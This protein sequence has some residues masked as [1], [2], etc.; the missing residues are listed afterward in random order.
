MS[1]AVIFP[2]QASVLSAFGTLVTPVRLDLVRS[3]LGLLDAID[4]DRTGTLFEQMAAEGR[5]F[6]GPPAVPTNFDAT[7]YVLGVSR[8]TVRE[9]LREL[10]QD[11][12]VLVHYFNAFAFEARKGEFA[13]P[14]F[15]GELARDANVKT[16]VTTHHGPW[17]DAD[18]TRERMIADLGAIFSG[19]I[20]CGEDLMSFSL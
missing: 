13:G 3:A 4:W 11:A 12:D 14:R 7:S 10:V 16:L 8:I 15:A 18:G 19:R 9:A 17:I 5:W 1:R 2:P 6:R 20:V